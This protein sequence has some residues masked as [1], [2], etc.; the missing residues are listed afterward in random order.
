[1][2]KTMLSYTKMILKRVSFEPTLF[3]KEVKKAMQ[4]LRPF[5]IKQLSVWILNYIKEKPEL[6][7]CQPYLR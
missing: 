1:M 3:C 4:L 7:L 6:Q 2:A 5:E